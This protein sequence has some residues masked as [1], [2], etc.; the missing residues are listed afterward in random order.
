[1][2][3]LHDLCESARE[4]LVQGNVVGDDDISGTADGTGS[5]PSL[6]AS[7]RDS[8]VCTYVC[9]CVCSSKCFCECVRFSFFF[10][11]VSFFVFHFFNVSFFFFFLCIFERVIACVHEGN[12]RASA[13]ANCMSSVKVRAPVL[14]LC[15]YFSFFCAFSCVLQVSK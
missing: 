3:K 6:R 9:A 4:R 10:F 8:Q 7:M 15:P 11:L 5:G 13:Y 14:S 1:M 2:R 12:M